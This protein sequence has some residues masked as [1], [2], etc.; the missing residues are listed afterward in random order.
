MIFEGFLCHD[1]MEAIYLK[2]KIYF[3]LTLKVTALLYI[4]NQ[5]TRITNI[6]FPNL[7]LITMSSD[8][9]SL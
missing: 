8:P 5:I 9:I 4:T 2:F 3:Y 1:V 7:S 6:F